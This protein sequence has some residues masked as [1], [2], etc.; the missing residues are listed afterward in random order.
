M[1]LVTEKLI[2]SWF[3]TMKNIQMRNV[4]LKIKSVCYLHMPSGGG[5][6]EVE[7]LEPLGR[8]TVLVFKVVDDG[9]GG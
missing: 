5:L 9:L 8:R 4:F 2:F 3:I 6:A 1:H 7:A